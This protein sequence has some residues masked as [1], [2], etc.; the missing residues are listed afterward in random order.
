MLLKADGTYR[1]HAGRNKSAYA[2][3]NNDTRLNDTVE[4]LYLELKDG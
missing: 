3:D 1:F 2:M 4:C